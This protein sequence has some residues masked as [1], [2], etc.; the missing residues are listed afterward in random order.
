MTECLASVNIP[1]LTRNAKTLSVQND[2][3]YS[4]VFAQKENQP[5]A[6]MCR[7]ADWGLRIGDCG[8]TFDLELVT[9]NFEFHAVDSVCARK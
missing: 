4:I 9:R 2:A 8:L 1:L 3:L 6:D 7:I 5:D